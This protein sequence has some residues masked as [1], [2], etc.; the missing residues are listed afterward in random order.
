M[1]KVH[2]TIV[3]KLTGGNKSKYATPPKMYEQMSE[4]YFNTYTVYYYNEYNTN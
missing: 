2:H 4:I 1:E 3:P